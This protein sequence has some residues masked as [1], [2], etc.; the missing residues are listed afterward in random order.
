MG[1]GETITCAGLRHEYVVDG[2]PVPALDGIELTVP[3]G[4]SAAIAGPSGSG[5]STLL[6]LLAGLQRPTSGT[7]H[8]GETDLTALSERELLRVRATRLAVVAQ[9]PYRNL[10]PYA[11]SLDNLEFAQRAPRSHGRRDLPALLPLL[12]ELGLAHLAGT[13]CDRLS[14]GE[15]Q[16]LA[17]AAAL[18]TGPTALVTDE[19]TS[20]LDHVNRAAVADL[21]VAICAGRGITVVAVTHDRDLAS[22]LGRTVTIDSGR[23][24]EA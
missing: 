23:I 20:Q 19:P 1:P 22:R 3:G 6:T 9:N 14:G 16:R 24:S 15:R 10:L 4:T 17:L 13:R 8:L 12:D 5:K 2:E 21:L 18:A 7:I 11:S